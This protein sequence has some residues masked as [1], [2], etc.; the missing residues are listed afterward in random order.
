MGVDNNIKEEL[1]LR[2]FNR[3]LLAQPEPVLQ[4]Y[5]NLELHYSELVDTAKS[6]VPPTIDVDKLSLTERLAFDAFKLRQSDQYIAAKLER[7]RD[8]ET[9]DME[10]C[11]MPLPVSAEGATQELAPPTMPTSGWLEGSVAIGTIIV[12]GPT[13]ALRF[14]DAE[15]TK[16][17]AE[18]QA[19]LSWLASQALS[20]KV[21][22]VH[23]IH[24]VQINTPANPGAPDLE[25]LWRDPTMKSLGYSASWQ[26][27]VD[28]VHALRDR[29]QTQWAYVAFFVNILWGTLHTLE[30]EDHVLSC[31]TTTTGGDPTILIVSLLTR[32][33]ISS[34]ALMSIKNLDAIAAANGDASSNR[35]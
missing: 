2:E 7:P 6:I 23:D 27:V 32:Q 21:T 24:L 1:V 13:G 25:A 8:K 5:G 3:V 12:N 29:M 22:F 16:V 15:K 26:G 4:R 11:I 9:W 19:G 10:G 35:T 20:S 18:V 33:A 31:S 28:Y 14:T 30:W 34:A 17:I